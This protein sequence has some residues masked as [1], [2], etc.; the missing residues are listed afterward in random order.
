M[1]FAQALAIPGYADRAKTLMTQGVCQLQAGQRAE[2][3]RSLIQAYEIDAGNPVIGYNL[4]SLLAQR[5]DYARA[6]FFIR[7]VNN[8]P[9]ANAESLWLGIKVERRLND[10]VAMNQLADQLKKR[11]GR[12]PEAA[13]FERRAFDE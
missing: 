2:A 9:S 7:R 4:A 13:A 10:E 1:Q 3:E 6:Q 11:F 5:E 12:S 8:S